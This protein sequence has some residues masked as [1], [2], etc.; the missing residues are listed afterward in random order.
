MLL[1]VDVSKIFCD[2][3]HNFFE[4]KEEYEVSCVNIITCLIVFKENTN[5]QVFTFS[6][7]VLNMVLHVVLHLVL[8]F[9]KQ[10]NGVRP[11]EET[12]KDIDGAN[13]EFWFLVDLEF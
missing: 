9:I 11:T 13:F 4:M 2:G 1:K 5:T 7:M 10:R 3:E 8:N 12:E 6:T